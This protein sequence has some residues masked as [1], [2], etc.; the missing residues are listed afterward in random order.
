MTDNNDEK[1]IWV[2]NGDNAKLPSG[3]FSDLQKAE[4]WI[5]KNNL[6]GILTRY[7][8]DIGAYDWA[9]KKGYFKTKGDP[10]KMTSQFIQGFTSASL[11]HNHYEHNY[12][13]E[14]GD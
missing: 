9:I 8:I 3:V 13:F 11:E 7:P 14:F 1:Y 4:E 2:F 10:S 5:K 6:A 12:D